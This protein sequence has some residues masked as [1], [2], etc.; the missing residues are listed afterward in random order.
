MPSVLYNWEGTGTAI[1]EPIPRYVGP[2]RSLFHFY[3][4]THIHNVQE[5]A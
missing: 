2:P 3:G 5:T 1:R 4:S